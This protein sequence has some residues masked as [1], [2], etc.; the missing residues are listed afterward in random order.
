MPRQALILLGFYQRHRDMDQDAKDGIAAKEAKHGEKMIEIKVRFW[1][2]GIED[3]ERIRPKHAWGSGVVRIT[4]NKSH[5]IVP[6]RARTFNSL[7]ELG[8]VIERVL[9][10]HGVVIHHS[11]KMRKY[12]AERPSRPP[13][14]KKKLVDLN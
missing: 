6:G 2:D 3:A 9:I 12:M 14:T 5:S 13:R 4:K 7:L 10:E 8:G 11:D 1:T